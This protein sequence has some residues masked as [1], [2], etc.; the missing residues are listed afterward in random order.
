[1]FVQW[2]SFITKNCFC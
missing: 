1:M 2:N